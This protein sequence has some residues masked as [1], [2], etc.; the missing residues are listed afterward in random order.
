MLLEPWRLRGE[1]QSCPR[2]AATIG[3]RVTS[4]TH[5]TQSTRA[6]S[7]PRLAMLNVKCFEIQQTPSEPVHSLR[8]RRTE[9]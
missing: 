3:A 5:P 6:R 1:N 2:L 7:L 4:T 8:A 9:A